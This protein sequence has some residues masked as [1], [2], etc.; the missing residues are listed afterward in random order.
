M[1]GITPTQFKTNSMNFS[2]YDLCTL[3]MVGYERPNYNPNVNHIAERK[4]Y[5][6]KLV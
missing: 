5:A 1:I 6:R 3:F 4:S 2:I